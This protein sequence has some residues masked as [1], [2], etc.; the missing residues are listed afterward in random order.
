MF[1]THFPVYEPSITNATAKQTPP[2]EHRHLYNKHT[3]QR[4]SEDT[5]S[6]IYKSQWNIIP[7]FNLGRLNAKHLFQLRYLTISEVYMSCTSPAEGVHRSPGQL[8]TLA[9]HPVIV[10]TFQCTRS[11]RPGGYALT[12]LRVKAHTSHGRCALVKRDPTKTHKYQSNQ[13]M[14]RFFQEGYN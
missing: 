10:K 7:R 5:E 4:T 1:P 13:E 8:L 3:M 6:N 12:F 11:K 2:W 9:P 14:E